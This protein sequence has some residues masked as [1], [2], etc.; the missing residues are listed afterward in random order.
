MPDTHDTLKKQPRTA[1][2]TPRQPA[3]KEVL[4]ARPVPGEIDHC[5]L[6]SE[7]IACFPKILAELAK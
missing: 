4:R 5:A 1:T 2:T 3:E 6:T 7:I